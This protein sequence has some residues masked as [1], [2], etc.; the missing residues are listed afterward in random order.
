MIQK[1]KLEDRF[2]IGQFHIEGFGTTIRLN[3]KQNGGGIMLL[4]KEGIPIKLLSSNIAPDQS[5]YIKINLKKKKWFLNRS[6]N[7]DK[8]FL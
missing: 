4:S 7:P 5:F 2:P 8:L 6:Y 1:T 3:C